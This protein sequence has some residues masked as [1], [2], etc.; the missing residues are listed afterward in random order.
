LQHDG[1]LLVRSLSA[2]TTRRVDACVTSVRCTVAGLGNELTNVT[3]REGEKTCHKQTKSSHTYTH[4]DDDDA[5]ET[6]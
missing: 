3:K 2:T 6:Q 1:A 4:L 5:E